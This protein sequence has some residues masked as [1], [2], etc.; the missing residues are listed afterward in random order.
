MTECCEGAEGGAD[1]MA[2]AEG[3]DADDW[4]SVHTACIFLCIRIQI[5]IVCDM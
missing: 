1:G 5:V 2:G 3:A 4:V